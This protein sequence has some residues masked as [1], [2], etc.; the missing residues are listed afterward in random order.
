MCLQS[1]SANQHHTTRTSKTK[2]KKTKSPKGVARSDGEGSPP[3][4][5]VKKSKK[6][7]VAS[8]ERT[9]SSDQGS[10]SKDAVASDVDEKRSLSSDF[11]PA[12]VTKLYDAGKPSVRVTLRSSVVSASSPKRTVGPRTP[13]GPEPMSVS[14]AAVTFFSDMILLFSCGELPAVVISKV[15]GDFSRL[16]L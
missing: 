12:E 6:K 2:T 3:P 1:S 9:P 8:A 5:H 15:L 13:P 7:K 16:N 11:Q 4:S 14:F 10:K